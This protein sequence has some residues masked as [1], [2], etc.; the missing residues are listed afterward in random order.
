MSL[1]DE[2]LVSQSA[3]RNGAISL[4]ISVAILVVAMVPFH[5]A[6]EVVWSAIGMFV[7]FLA[8]VIAHV[9]DARDRRRE[10]DR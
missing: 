9:L 4:G 8:P 7:F 3:W 2:P 10:R 1:R 5:D 6:G